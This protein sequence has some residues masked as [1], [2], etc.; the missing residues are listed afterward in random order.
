VTSRFSHT[1]AENLRI[2]TSSFIRTVTVGSGITPDLL[3]LQTSQALAGSHRRWGI[4]P[5]PEDVRLNLSTLLYRATHGPRQT[6]S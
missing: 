6:F 1:S 3:T 2:G 4:A 5:R